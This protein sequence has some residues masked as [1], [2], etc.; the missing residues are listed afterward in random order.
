[1]G[2]KNKSLNILITNDDGIYAQGLLALYR[3]L[4]R[5]HRVTGRWWRRIGGAALWDM[6]IA[7][8]G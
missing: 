3:I 5:H 6:D 7:N 1:M 8:D 4:S 2:A